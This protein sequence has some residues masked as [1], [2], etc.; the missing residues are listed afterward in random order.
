MSL[1]ACLLR[2]GGWE[3]PFAERPTKCAKR[4]QRLPNMVP[5]RKLQNKQVCARAIWGTGDKP[6]P[7][8][9]GA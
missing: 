3:N 6:S 1:Y 4:A 7:L 8:V 9:P 2:E 5:S